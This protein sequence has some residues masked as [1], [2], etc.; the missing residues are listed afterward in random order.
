MELKANY[1]NT[2]DMLYKISN[3]IIKYK[4][5]KEI[6]RKDVFIDQYIDLEDD[7]FQYWINACNIN[8]IHGRN[9]FH[10]ENAIAKLLE[11][12]ITKESNFA[13]RLFTPKLDINI[14][15][16]K[17]SFGSVINRTVLYPF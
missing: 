7:A 14:W 15:G 8:K 13:E 6:H 5:D 9:D 11:Y 1:N 16:S 4:I 10:Y 2:L 3:P 12:G 17:K